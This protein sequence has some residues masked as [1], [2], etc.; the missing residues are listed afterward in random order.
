MHLRRVLSAVAL[1]PPFVLLVLLGTPLHFFLLVA[2]AILVGLHEFYAMAG[3]AGL[4]PLTLLGMAGG[5]LI[6]GTQF[7][8]ASPPWL[9]STLAGWTILLLIC[10]LVES[11][12]PKEAASRVAITLFGMIYVAGLLSVPP[13]LRAMGPGK[14]YVIYLVL[15]T[16]A[17]DVGA[18]YVGSSFGR[19]P[20][21]QSISA[22]KTVEGSLGGLF[23]SV[24]ASCLAKLLFWERLGAVQAL[25]LGVGLGIMGQV[26]DLC[27]SML[28]RSF[29]VK[30][31]GTL[32]PGH[33]GLLDRVDSLLFTGPVFFLAV[34][35]GWVRD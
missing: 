22:G 18:F 10:L 4:R 19:R 7:F 34:L 5:L 31:A 6:S 23:C 20:L 15:V 24:L 12:D 32:I 9:A 21:C 25:S 27:E 26:G 17:G 35:A 1:L 33:G 28:K 11:R 14:I 30:D 13:L 2:I 16:W 29:G 8:G 3:A